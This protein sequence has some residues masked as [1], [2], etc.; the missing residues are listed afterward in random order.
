M[1]K[2][3]DTEGVS[4]YLQQLFKSTTKKLILISPYVRLH[5]RYKSSLKNLDRLK[6][7]I[8]LVCRKD[9]LLEKEESWLKDLSS[10][11]LSFNKHLHAKCY[12]NE[13]EAII[14]S[15]NLHDYSQKNN[16]EM[17]IH[18]R[19]D[20]DHDLYNEISKEAD[21]LIRNSEKIETTK[22]KVTTKKTL[23][24]IRKKVTEKR[25]D[26]TNKLLDLR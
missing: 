2:F 21:R 24:K 19:R 3:L 23:L 22:T 4:H 11:R 10:I 12:L 8:Y 9:E 15:M 5:E 20:T 16:Y 7:A 13:N 1:A 25:I 26:L 17:G 6:I 18:V 14:T